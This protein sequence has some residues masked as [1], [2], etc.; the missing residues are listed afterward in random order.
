MHFNTKL[1]EPIVD[2]SRPTQLLLGDAGHFV[3]IDVRA[4]DFG[5]SLLLQPPIPHCRDSRLTTIPA[6]AC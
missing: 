6:P 2:E 1:L 4:R 5:Q 3:L